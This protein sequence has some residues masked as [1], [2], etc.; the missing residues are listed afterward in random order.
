METTQEQD[1]TQQ[2]EMSTDISNVVND[3]IENIPKDFTDS[4]GENDDIQQNE[5]KKDRYG[6]HFD[7][8]YHQSN[9]DGSPKVSAAGLLCLKPGRKNVPGKDQIDN[10]KSHVHIPGKEKIEE[11]QKVVDPE[12][13]KIAGKIAAETLFQMA[14][15]MG[16]KEFTPNNNE[17]ES[18][19]NSF[20]IYFEAKEIS[21]IPPGIALFLTVGGYLGVRAVPIMERKREEKR[22]KLEEIEI[23]RNGI[24]KES[25][26]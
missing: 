16:G 3:A 20:S 1:N 9:S 19:S 5:T 14:Q 7:P 10:G 8:K 12:Q 23:N 11:Q 6:N 26:K 4:N 21:D 2:N 18:I 17:R 24:R 15:M 22:K 13:F 25:E